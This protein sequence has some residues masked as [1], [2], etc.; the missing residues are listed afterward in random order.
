MSL[1][2]PFQYPLMWRDEYSPLIH[3]EKHRTTTAKNVMVWFRLADLIAEGLVELIRLPSDFDRQL[4]RRNMESSQAL[5]DRHPELKKIID[6]Y[7]SHRVDKDSEESREWMTLLQPDWRILELA[8]EAD[9]A[10]SEEDAL[11]FLSFIQRRREAHPYYLDG[12]ENE[13]VAETTGSSVYDAVQVATLSGAYLLTDLEARWRQ[14]EYLQ[15]ESAQPVDAR[16]RIARGLQNISLPMAPHLNLQLAQRIREENQLARVRGLL[17]K[18]MRGASGDRPLS[19]Q[20]ARAFEHELIDAIAEAKDE[21][22]NIDRELLK[23]T[24]GEIATLATMYGMTGGALTVTL[25]AAAAAGTLNLIG[26]AWNRRTFRSRYPAAMFMDLPL[27][28]K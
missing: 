22:A 23:Y 4:T 12:T 25:G 13:I 6:E 15:Q 5:V 11:N 19:D 24:A 26:S 21:Y 18:L 3:P 14:F 7:V 2:D 16:A 27:G 17:D 10:A 1:A 8:R 9:A 28:G 20:E